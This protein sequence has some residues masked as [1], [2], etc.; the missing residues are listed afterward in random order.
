MAQASMASVGLAPPYTLGRFFQYAAVSSMV[1]AIGS[2]EVVVDD[3]YNV[4]RIRSPLALRRMAEALVDAVSRDFVRENTLRGRGECRGASL[5]VPD[6]DAVFDC[7]SLEGG[8]RLYSF[9]KKRDADIILGAGLDECHT[10][11]DRGRKRV[12][13]VG[14]AL[15]YAKKV[16][17]RGGLLGGEASDLPTMAKAT[18]FSRYKVAGGYANA[19][20]IPVSVDTL[21]TVLVGGVL[22]FLGRPGGVEY[23]LIPSTVVAG[24]PVVAGILRSAR[25]WRPYL[26]VRELPV[27]LEDALSL[28]LS[29]K[30]ASREVSLAIASGVVSR[31]RVLAVSSGRR[32]V[33]LGSIPLTL[34]PARVFG[35][36]TLGGLLYLAQLSASQKQVEGLKDVAAQCLRAAILFSSHPCTDE[37]LIACIRELSRLYSSSTKLPRTIRNTAGKLVSWLA[38]DMDRALRGCMG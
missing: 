1:K 20:R 12:T 18:L 13:W 17:E 23:Y 38:G 15:S 30:V 22:S 6:V 19:E 26:L 28:E 32:P 11:D 36:G 31:S 9:G 29:Y 25:T 27:G 33:V 8:P 5:A 16:L 34:L 7:C 35:A 37:S 24:F 3:D 2:A 21:G 10:I 4:V 14:G